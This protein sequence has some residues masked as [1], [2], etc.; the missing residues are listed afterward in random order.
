MMTRFGFVSNSSSS[1]FILPKKEL[2][3]E[4]REGFSSWVNIYNN[5]NYS[6]QE[7]TSIMETANY[8]FGKV[9]NN[10]SI[11]EQLSGL[12]ITGLY[13]ELEEY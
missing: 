3:L 11:K 2:T 12:G 9:S 7:D 5:S 13:Y 8:F 6:I 4:Q 10:C 1:S